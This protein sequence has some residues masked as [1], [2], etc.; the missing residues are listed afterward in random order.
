MTTDGTSLITVQL[1]DLGGNDLSTS[2]GT[3][4]L[5]TDLGNLTGLADN[6]DGTWTATL[7]VLTSGT[8][9]VTGK[10]D[11]N[12]ISD[13]ADVVVSLGAAD[14]TKSTISAAPTTVTTEASSTITIQAKDAAGNDLSTGGDDFVL[15]TNHGVLSSLTDN[16]DGT[17]TATLTDTTAETATVHGTLNGQPMTDAATVTFT[18]G[19]ADPTTTSITPSPASMTTDGSST[20]TVQAKD[21]HGNNVTSGGD[22]V[23]LNS[24]SG[25]V[26][27]VT[28]HGNGTYTATFTSGTIATASITGTLNGVD[29]DDSAS[30]IVSIG[31]PAKLDFTTQPSGG[32]A[33]TA[34]TT[35]PSV[36]IEDSHGNLETAASGNVTLS[37]TAPAG[38]AILTCT[39]NPK[40]VASGVATF[41]G[42]RIDKAGD[43]TL[44]ATKAG[45][46]S[47]ESD[48]LTITVGPAD[49]TKSTITAQPV[50]TTIDDSS[51]ITIQAKD[52]G[53]NDLSSGGDSFLLQT[54]H[55]VLSG[56]ND[57]TDGTYT[58]TLADTTAE[59]DHLSGTLSGQALTDTATVVFGPGAADFHNSTVGASPVSMTTDGTSTITVQTKDAG[60]N[61]LTVGGDLVVLS[62]DIG[63]LSGVTDH[64]NGTYTATLTSGTIGTAHIHATLNGTPTDDSASVV[65]SV[66]AKAKLAFTLQPGGGPGAAA[67]STQPD[68][69]VE[70]AHGNVVTTGS[71]VITLSITPPAGGAT[72]TCTGGNSKATALGVAQFGGCKIDKSGDYTLTATKSGL[73]SAASATFTITNVDPVATD[74]TPA[75]V[76][77]DSAPTVFSVL[78]NDSDANGDTLT[79]DSVGSASQGT[80]SVSGG[81]TTVTYTPNADA[82]GS[83]T[84]TYTIDDGNGGVATANVNVTITPVN[85]VPSFTLGTDQTVLEDAGPQTITGFAAGSAGPSNES[86]QGL[87]Y[88]VDLNTNLALFSVAPAIS[89]SGDLTFTTAPNANGTA[90]ITVHLH[91]DGGVT[92]G[93]VDSSAMQIFNITVTAVNDPPVAVADGPLLVK[94]GLNMVTTAG[95]GVLANDTDVDT[96]HPALT[97]VLDTNVTHGSLVLNADGS[98]TYTPQVSYIGSDSFTYHAFDGAS[99]GNTVTVTFTVYV[100]HNPTAVGDIFS[101]VT[102]PACT[103]LPVLT[104]DNA[105]NPDVGE[106]LTITHATHPSHGTV[107]ITGGGSGL[108]YKP[109]SG[110]IGNDI[111]SYTI[112]DGVFTSSASVLVHVVKDTVKPVVTAP[113]AKLGAQVIGS[114][115]VVTSVQWTGSDVGLGI[116]KYELQVSTNGGSYTGV[117]LS[118]PTSTAGGKAL[119]YGRTYRFRVR[120]TDKA[121]N[122]GAWVYGLTFKAQVYQQSYFSFTGLWWVSN[123]SAYSGGHAESTVNPGATATYSPT[124]YTFGWVAV[125]GPTRNVAQ[126]WIDGVLS[127]TVNLHASTTT[128]KV[129]VWSKTFGSSAPHTFQIVY[130]GPSGQR[131]DVDAFVVFH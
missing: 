126:V 69:S 86:G 106:I 100:N 120:A 101:V 20:I 52:A 77:E 60:G 125:K 43:Y 30:V 127:A 111:F 59:T 76:L 91:D 48:S 65:V 113:F 3:V 118:K 6:G 78:P 92:N 34:W 36:A 122:V 8:A 63:A 87:T 119:T 98:F 17:Y 40:S 70:D 58:A 84:F 95:T 88:V 71:D 90:A 105:V 103:S 56:F 128:T 123:W 55:G 5:D 108:C 109:T 64:D 49:K 4:T 45:L 129:I 51:I 33:A 66:G 121:G 102:G 22:I 14:E 96:S 21:S 9:H 47:D 93:G 116:A 1:K 50:S 67:W 75:A 28:D 94:Q 25:S 130:T 31:A 107:T 12:D 37:I 115:T 57:N 38:G 80:A 83:D 7:T 81:G 16:T 29:I 32:N 124:G 27:G 42:C 97:A 39:A 10:L 74:D 46:S 110:F 23:V 18:P 11:G 89:A 24:D 85:D 104:N 13:T 26:S 82:N 131:A 79:I 15:S 112:S 53:G 54:D 19:D 72:L 41:A 117:G 62:T 44:T 2:G 35:Q 73:T 68:V 99:A 61:N 114:S